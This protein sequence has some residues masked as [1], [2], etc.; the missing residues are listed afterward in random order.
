MAVTYVYD[1]RPVRERED[2]E[3][4][5]QALYMAI[6]DLYELRAWP[7]MIVIDGIPS[8]YM[9]PPRWGEEDWHCLGPKAPEL[10]AAWHR[11]CDRYFEEYAKKQDQRGLER[12]PWPPP[13]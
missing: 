6:S 5:D 10:Q 9:R 4:L 7:R 13:F 12:V 1:D 3:T 8:M 2:C 11:A